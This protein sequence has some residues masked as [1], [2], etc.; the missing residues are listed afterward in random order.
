MI[1]TSCEYGMQATVYLAAAGSREYVPIRQIGADLDLSEAFLAKVLQTLKQAGLVISR[2]GPKGGVALAQ[3]ADAITLKD[4]IIA[5]DGDALF[6][7]CVMGLPGCGTATPC[8]M[9]ESWH[10]VR[11]HLTTL[12]ADLTLSRVAVDAYPQLRSAGR[13][14]RPRPLDSLA[15][16]P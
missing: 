14:K 16:L 9:H 6:T 11:G 8:P 5:L 7:R 1:S 12:L 4:I 13:F 15:S 2:R 10:D 3:P